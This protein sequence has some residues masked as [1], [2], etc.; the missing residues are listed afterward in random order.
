MKQQPAIH[1]F[2]YYW[3]TIFYHL[4]SATNDKTILHKDV[5]PLFYL[6]CYYMDLTKIVTSQHFDNQLQACI[7]S[8]FQQRIYIKFPGILLE[9]MK[10]LK[11]DFYLHFS[12]EKLMRLCP[13]PEFSVFAGR[14][15]DLGKKAHCKSRGRKTQN[16]MNGILRAYLCK[17][18]KGRGYKEIIPFVT[19]LD[20]S[21][22][23][24]L[25]VHSVC[26]EYK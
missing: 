1:V 13:E 20:S 26:L 23:F 18:K 9:E 6:L 14:K 25:E 7:K 8:L 11:A 17:S 16:Q 24:L 21:S 10:A 22:L 2:Y 19:N 12:K 4:L 15:P 3:S 5:L